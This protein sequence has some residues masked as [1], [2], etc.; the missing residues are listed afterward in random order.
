MS[1][2]LSPGQKAQ[3]TARWA[4]IMTKWLITYNRARGAAWKVVEFGGPTGAE[5]VGVVDLIAIRKNHAIPKAG[6]KRGDLFEIV[7]IQSKGGGA[8]PPSAADITRLRTVAA[9]HRAK[10][11]VL[12]TWR[13]NTE[14]SLARLVRGRW[15]PVHAREIFG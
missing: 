6:L 3:Y 8:L 11:V 12:A 5:S 7:L 9:H 13:R 2:V 4:R 14:L 1:M 15:V 10:S